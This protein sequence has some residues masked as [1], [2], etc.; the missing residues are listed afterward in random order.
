MIS[1]SAPQYGDL[2]RGC[3]IIEADG[4]GPKVLLRPDGT[5]LKLFRRKRMLSSAL[6]FPYARRFADNC[7][8]LAE[9]GIP[10][11][12]V[13]ALYRVGPIERDVVHYSPLPGNTVRQLIREGLA[14]G[15]ED[16]LR[17]DLGQFV[18]RLHG[19][20]IL[21][22]SLHLGNV[23]LTPTACL[24][25]I[26]VGDMGIRRGPLPERAILRNF[27]HLGRYP[28]EW[29]WLLSNSLFAQRYLECSRLT[30]RAREAASAY[31]T[32]VSPSKARREP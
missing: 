1:L 21:F 8:R 5:M 27:D 4:F 11:P 31:L 6:L 18:A 24:G 20:G 30:L 13:L 15:Q 2:A 9:L 29:A 23:V 17:S 25:L 14:P 3:E 22:R 16:A 28:D 26:D 10:S 12:T 7:R 19:S 32:A